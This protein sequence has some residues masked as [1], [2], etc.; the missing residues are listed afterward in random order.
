MTA[1]IRLASLLMA[2]AASAALLAS[3][4]GDDDSETDDFFE[5]DEAEDSETATE[6]P[7]EIPTASATTVPSPTAD[8]TAGA[9]DEPVGAACQPNPSPVDEGDPSILVDSPAPGDS[10]EGIVEV[11]GEARVFEATVSLA[12]YD[13]DGELLA[14]TFST[15]SEGAPAFG[16]LEARVGYAGVDEQTEGC[17][18]VF[19]S[20]AED[21]SP[22]HV[23]Q[24]PLE[25]APA[26]GF[27]DAEGGAWCP[28]NPDPATS[29]N[30]QVEQPLPDETVIGAARVQGLA[31]VF[32]AQF[33]VR[34][35]DAAGNIVIEQPATTAE[36]QVLSEFDVGVPFVVPHTQP[37]CI[38]LFEASAEDGSDTHIYAIPV[39]LGV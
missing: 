7:G 19:E 15:T 34:I 4:G 9:T 5:P 20:S 13:A 10:V 18:W 1:R 27:I 35:Y 14:E 3:C 32:E 33:L 16:E 36:G 17:L 24:V 23:V 30:F 31:A 6:A 38:W 29:E 21:G 28:E 26:P 2:L 11:S 12:L 8:I 39:H 37:G 22:T 25:L